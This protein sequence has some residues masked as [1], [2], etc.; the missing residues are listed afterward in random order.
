MSILGAG[1]KS[2][3]CRDWS[4]E[5]KTSFGHEKQ[6]VGRPSLR[7]KDGPPRL[8]EYDQRARRGRVDGELVDP[9]VVDEGGTVTNECATIVVGFDG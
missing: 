9:D 4:L 1:T 7:K 8:T 3:C 2:T 5:S 6:S